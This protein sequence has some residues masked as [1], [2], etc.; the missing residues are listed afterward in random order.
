MR[1]DLSVNYGFRS[2]LDTTSHLYFTLQ[3]L[4]KP[5]QHTRLRGGDRASELDHYPA[6]RTR[7]TAAHLGNHAGQ[8]R[9]SQFIVA[10]R[11][12]HMLDRDFRLLIRE[13]NLHLRLVEHEQ[14]LRRLMQHSPE[15]LSTLGRNRIDLARPAALT[16][17]AQR[18]QAIPRQLLERRINRSVADPVE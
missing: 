13:I 17:A 11:A 4:A 6:H 1:N 7:P 12:L 10:L 15:V 8:D 3:L 14:R 5:L 16:F 18:D 2:R 9:R